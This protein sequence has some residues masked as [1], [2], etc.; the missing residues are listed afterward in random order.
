M[1][2]GPDKFSVMLSFYLKKCI[3]YTGIQ[4]QRRMLLLFRINFI[5]GGK[6]SI[7]KRRI[8][9]IIPTLT[10]QE[11]NRGVTNANALIT[12]LFSFFKNVV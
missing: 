10:L 6:K 12:P 1:Y 2:S 8:C 4:I 9:G 3:Y 5:S 7:D 11:N